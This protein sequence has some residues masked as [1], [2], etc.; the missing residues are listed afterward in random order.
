[1]RGGEAGDRDA[2][3]RAEDVVE[4]RLFAE[5]DRGRIAAMLATSSL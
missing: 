1:L 3:G 5:G 4:M 2:V